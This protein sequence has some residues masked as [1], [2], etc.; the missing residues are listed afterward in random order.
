MTIRDALIESKLPKADA[1]ILLSTILKHPRSWI[2]AHEDEALPEGSQQ[3]WQAWTERARGGEP[4]AYITGTKEFFGRSF[5]VNPST[6]IPRGATEELVEIA[7]AALKS[8]NAQTFTKEIDSGIAACVDIWDTGVTCIVDI[9]TGSGCIGVTMA[10]ERTDLRVIATDISPD[11]LLTAREN[12]SALGARHIDF[13]LGDGMDP[14]ADLTEPFLIVSNPPYI[15][16][17]I[18]LAKNVADFE[19]HSALFAG[20]DGMD[21]LTRLVKAAHSHAY[22]KG[23]VLEC[24][25]EQA[26]KLLG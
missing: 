7:L 11:A 2:F 18:T 13:R 9:G 5:R 23:F 26:Q 19:P 20:I 4:V 21:V 16:D 15:P 22:C 12:A 1:E 3:E 10:L 17:G 8:G 25:M 14:F 24:R 6:L